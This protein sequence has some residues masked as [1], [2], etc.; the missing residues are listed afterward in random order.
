MR[1]E[2]DQAWEA[3]L[4]APP[5]DQGPWRVLADMLLAEGQAQGELMQLE[6]DLE[7]G[8]LKGLARGRYRR[9]KD[10]VERA[11]LP[12]GTGIHDTGF[13]RG[14]LVALAGSAPHLT[15]PADDERWRSVQ[16]LSLHYPALVDRE[17]PAPKTPLAGGR[18]LALERLGF[19]S[20]E[21]VDLLVDSPGK[22][23]LRALALFCPGRQARPSWA[24]RWA[25][26]WPSHP[27]LREVRFTHG[28]NLADGEC[29]ARLDEWLEPLL[30]APLERVTV[31]VALHQVPQLHAWRQAVRSR[32]ALVADVGIDRLHVEVRPDEL[33]LGTDDPAL[34]AEERLR[35]GKRLAGNVTSTPDTETLL[36]M[37]WGPIGST[38]PPV[39]WPR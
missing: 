39:R 8:P 23:R 29:S 37:H 5:E 2:L 26:L 30:E 31:E 28:R 18:L 12:P 19:L 11:L 1:S 33:V 9:V 4:D 24:R 15:G 10:E 20:P 32:F 38:L 3:A 25:A 6:L 35:R 17:V 22:P 16:R 36:R 7:L 13:R 21:A 27:R 14:A 34:M